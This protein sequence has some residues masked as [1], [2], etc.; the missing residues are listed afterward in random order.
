ME[1]TEYWGLR[2]KPFEEFCDTR[3]FFESDDHREALDRML[4]VVNDK[5]MNIGLLTGE[6]GSGKT[7]TK[8]VFCSSLSRQ[9]F[10]VVAFENSQLPFTD[11]LYDIVERI[12]FRDSRIALLNDQ[13]LPSRA[14]KYQLTVL[15]K[16]KLETL[17]YEEKR[18]LVLIF[19]EAQQI[20]DG[21]LDEIK[22]L[23][24]ITAATESFM[25]IFLV[26]QPELRDK[27]YKLK[28]I[29]QRIFLRF[30]LNNLDFPGTDKYIRHRLRVAGLDKGS[31]FTPQSGE[32]IFRSTGGVPREIN[33]L[34]K[35][36]L[37]YS[38]SQNQTEIDRQDIQIILDDIQRHR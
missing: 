25:T 24:N 2:G 1:Y 23:T 18:H 16:K 9:S 12:T 34:C 31:I 19:D 15:L 13:A 14:D 30:H 28:Q 10:E 20:E 38:F 26:G 29:D 5:N 3:F 22:N 37:N 35:L 7:I 4:Y 17:A 27:I 32:L 36:A 33:R 6:I 11:I 8:Q 21:V